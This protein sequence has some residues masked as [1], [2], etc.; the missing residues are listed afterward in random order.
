[1]K[2]TSELSW[3]RK[4]KVLLNIFNLPL[5]SESLE[6]TNQKRKKQLVNNAIHSVIEK[7]SGGGT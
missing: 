6:N 5:L 4:M 3:F 7:R 1:M 2:F